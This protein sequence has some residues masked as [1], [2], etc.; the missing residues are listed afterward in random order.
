MARPRSRK[1]QWSHPLY[2]V[3]FCFNRGGVVYTEING[4]R[5]STH[6]RWHRN[7]KREALEVLEKR[8][9]EYLHPKKE[10]EKAEKVVTIQEAIGLFSATALQGLKQK[11]VQNY[12]RA[13]EACLP[14]TDTSV[15]DYDVLRP[16]FVNA[17]S[18]LTISENSKREHVKKIRKLFTFCIQEGWCERN[19]TVNSMPKFSKTK[20]K[21]F[22]RFEVDLLEDYFWHQNQFYMAILVLILGQTG[23]RIE[24]ILVQKWENVNKE[25]I[26]VDGKGEE[27]REI[28]IKPFLRLEYGIDKLRSIAPPDSKYLFGWRGKDSIARYLREAVKDLQLPA[29][30]FHAIRKM[31]E[32]EWIHVYGYPPHL[33]AYLCGHSLAVQEKHYLQKPTAKQLQTMIERV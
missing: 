25:R 2:T 9:D 7:N 5:K 11:T 17:L 31:R 15:K 32:N 19:P 24:E 29:T 4:R 22:T 14:S 21:I 20:R 12:I 33:A 28:P 6:L 13:F 3:G 18:K 30:G 1:D 26:F 23:M 8:I 10:E 27:K 16:Y